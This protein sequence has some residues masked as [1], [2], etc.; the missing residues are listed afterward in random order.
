MSSATTENETAAFVG[1]L[2]CVA[3]IQTFYQFTQELGEWCHCS[4]LAVGAE[5]II[6]V[7]KRAEAE[8][9][10]AEQVVPPL[11]LALAEPS[12]EKKH[13]M[14]DQQVSTVDPHHPRLLVAYRSSPCRRLPS[15]SP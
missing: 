13:T 15:S 3:S 11:L 9:V 12:E 10:V 7:T 1:L 6:A 5:W 2:D 4:G 8:V 14:D